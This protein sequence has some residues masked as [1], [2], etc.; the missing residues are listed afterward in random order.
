MADFTKSDLS[1]DHYKWEAKPD[2]DPSV[3]G[4]PDSTLFNRTQGYEVLYMLNKVL[5]STASKAD[6]HKAEKLIDEDLP[7]STR[8]QEDVKA[9]LEDEM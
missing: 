2:D 6:L 3:T 8:S 9:W 5:P 1:L 7:G 4:A